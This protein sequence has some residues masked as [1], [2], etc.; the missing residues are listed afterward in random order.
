MDE[1]YRAMAESSVFSAK[2]DRDTGNPRPRIAQLNIDLVRKIRRN[3][4]EV[5]STPRIALVQ[6]IPARQIRGPARRFPADLRVE[7]PVWLGS[8][9]IRRKI[10]VIPAHAGHIDERERSARI[11]ISRID[12]RLP[13]RRI[14]QLARHRQEGGARGTLLHEI[15]EV[16]LQQP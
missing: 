10:E 2:I 5:E 7:K 14:C 16:R 9:L 3:V 8:R 11:P 13:M 4:A 12:R 15:L 6:Q 1:T